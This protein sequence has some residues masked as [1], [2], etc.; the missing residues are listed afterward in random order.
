MCVS[1]F[2]NLVCVSEPYKCVLTAPVYWENAKV[3]STITGLQKKLFLVCCALPR[4]SIS[5]CT[6]L[7]RGPE[8]ELRIHART[9]DP[10][11]SI[12]VCTW[13]CMWLPRRPEFG[14]RIQGSISGC[15][16]G[17]VIAAPSLVCRPGGM[18]ASLILQLLATAVS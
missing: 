14:L 7:P 18:R 13:S 3:L 6:W 1:E 15:A 10:D 16:C 4:G 5:V 11:G 9:P 17:S 2:S 12:S 8:S